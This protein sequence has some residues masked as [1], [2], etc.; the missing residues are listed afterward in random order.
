M[1]LIFLYEYII[2]NICYLICM[3][4]LVKIGGVENM[5]DVGLLYIYFNFIK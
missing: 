4:Y 3:I 1:N 2:W 5:N